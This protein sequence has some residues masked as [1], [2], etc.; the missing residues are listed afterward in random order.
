MPRNA[1]PL[2]AGNWRGLVCLLLVFPV[3]ARIRHFFSWMRGHKSANSRELWEEFNRN[4]QG[5][6]EAGITVNLEVTTE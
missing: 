4:V 5:L 3:I 2:S 1:V 6:L